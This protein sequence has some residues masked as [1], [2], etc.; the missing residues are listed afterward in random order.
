LRIEEEQ[1]S[2]GDALPAPPVFAA[3]SR[4][5]RLLQNQ[6]SEKWR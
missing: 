1:Q 2:T 4:N 3:V 6:M 5:K